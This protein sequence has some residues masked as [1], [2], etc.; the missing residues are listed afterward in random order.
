MKI[1]I[2]EGKHKFENNYE[3]IEMDEIKNLTKAFMQ[4]YKL[5]KCIWNLC[6]E[7]DLTNRT[8][9]ALFG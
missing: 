4:I 6:G 1:V 3:S 2:S 7:A 5:E 9:G 8:L